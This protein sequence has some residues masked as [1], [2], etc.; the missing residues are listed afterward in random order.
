MIDTSQRPTP[1]DAYINALYVDLLGTPVDASGLVTWLNVLHG[2]GGRQAVVSGLL[3]STA[4]RGNV[5]QTTYEALL[6]RA[7]SPSEEYAGILRL[8][9]ARIE[10]FKAQV[11]GT[12]EFYT[13]A[14]STV[15]GFLA[16][17]GQVFL[18]QPID[19]TSFAKYT[20]QLNSGASRTTVAYEVLTSTPG[21]TATVNSI[22]A[23]LHLTPDTAGVTAAVTFL[24]HGGTDQGLI[25]ALATN[26]GFYGVAQ[27]NGE[28]IV[29]W[30]KQVYFDLFGTYADPTF[31][32]AMANLV[33][34]GTATP[35]QVVQGL[36]FLP[37][38]R[39]VAVT[40]LYESILGHGPDATGL[41]NASAFL[42]SGGTAE[43]LKAILISTPDFYQHEGGGT[44][45]GAL[46]AMYRYATGKPIPSNVLTALE[47]QLASGISFYQI[48]ASLLYSTTGVA[49]TIQGLYVT[50]VR[51]PATF[52]DYSSFS[53]ALS[54]GFVSDQAII[55]TLLT[56]DAYFAGL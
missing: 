47:G 49:N 45:A 30:A 46:T 41:T 28:T 48:T 29:Q 8:A 14:G 50:Y 56:T 37:Q 34:H 12:D 32:A 25:L 20:A 11:A 26:N 1:D 4:Y 55:A 27:G 54:G 39:Q 36:Q 10:A 31:T 52:T 21:Y 53:S 17:L 5:V 13:L 51:Q 18:G 6:G 19:A 35:L 3:A 42:A 33:E 40:N 38:Y 16:R 7:A 2:S 15:A 23:S 24:Q 9:T 43:N 44:N 22:Y